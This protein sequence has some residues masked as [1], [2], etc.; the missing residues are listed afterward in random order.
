MAE[1][2]LQRRDKAPEEKGREL[3]MVTREGRLDL[4]SEKNVDKGSTLVMRK[5]GE[6]RAAF[7]SESTPASVSPRMWRGCHLSC[8]NARFVS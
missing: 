3:R 8:S 4:D 2:G 6:E 7:G 5:R 1:R